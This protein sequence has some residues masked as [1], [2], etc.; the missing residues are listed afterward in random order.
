[1]V[2]DTLVVALDDVGAA[3][4]RQRDRLY[5][6]AKDTAVPSNMGIGRV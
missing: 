2:S 5:V 3:T 1:M 4:H 6:C